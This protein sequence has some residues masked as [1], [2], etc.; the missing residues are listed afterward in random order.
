M[1]RNGYWCR[2]SRK[3]VWRGVT[4]VKLNVCVMRLIIMYLTHISRKCEERSRTSGGT[5]VEKH[6]RA[7]GAAFHAPAFV[8]C[9]CRGATFNAAMSTQSLVYL[10]PLPTDSAYSILIPIFLFRSKAPTWFRGS[11]LSVRQGV[12]PMFNFAL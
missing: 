6:M 9:E 12:H 8:F 1:Y 4:L 2:L 3:F 11:K 10:A 7:H 5:R